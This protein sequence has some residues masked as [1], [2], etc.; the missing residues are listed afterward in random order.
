MLSGVGLGN[1]FSTEVVG[2]SYY[3]VNKSPSP[4]MDDKTLQEVWTSKKSS[5]THIKLFSC[6]AYIHVPKE[7]KSKLDVGTGED[8]G[9]SSKSTPTSPNYWPFRKHLR[10]RCSLTRSS[11]EG[12]A[13]QRC[14]QPRGISSGSNTGTTQH[15]YITYQLDLLHA[16]IRSTLA[17]Q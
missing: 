5:L 8:P 11:Y 14:L 6:E 16:S 2:I 7:N 1:K 9:F 15:S 12:V 13:G 4:V 17:M 3:L 10:S